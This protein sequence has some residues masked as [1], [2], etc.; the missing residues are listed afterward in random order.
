M[1]NES[2]PPDIRGRMAGIE[3]LS[4]SLGPTAGQIRAGSLASATSLRASVVIGGA[5]C[6]GGC[7]ALPVGLRSMWNFDAR[8]DAHVAQVRALRAGEVV[9]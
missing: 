1:W 2:I 4:F 9:A 7:L 8:T 5:A 6:A 3:L